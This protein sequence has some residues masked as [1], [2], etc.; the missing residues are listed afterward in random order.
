MC[1]T[2]QTRNYGALEGGDLQRLYLQGILH[3]KALRHTVSA[4]GGLAYGIHLKI[5]DTAVCVKCIAFCSVG[6]AA[7]RRKEKQIRGGR[8]CSLR[9]C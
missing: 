7:T 5:T 8:N 2:G 9:I 4:D 6:D 1:R 3:G